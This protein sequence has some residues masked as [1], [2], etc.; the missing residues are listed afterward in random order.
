MNLIATL[1]MQINRPLNA[2]GVF[3][4]LH[5]AV[6]RKQV[7]TALVKLTKEDKLRVKAYGK[8]K[9]Y[10]LNQEVFEVVQ[11]MCTECRQVSMITL[12]EWK[13]SGTQRGRFEGSRRQGKSQA[14]RSGRTKADLLEAKSE[15]FTR[16]GEATSLILCCS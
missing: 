10:W 5:R 8:S 2:T 3:E 11:Q 12:I 4:N 14:G 1:L 15:T 9:V 7:D 6:P 13:L 16:A